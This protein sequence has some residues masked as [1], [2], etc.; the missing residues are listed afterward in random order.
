[1]TES[2]RKVWINNTI[3]NES[4]AKVPIYDSALMF[5]DMVFEMTRS[6]NSKHFLLEEHIER[7][8][9]SAEYVNIDVPYSKSE[10]LSGIEEITNHHNK[11][12]DKDDEHR[13]MINLS[14]GLLGIYE[15]NV[16]FS[17]KGPLLMI[18]DFPLKW[19]VSGMSEYFD[20][21][22]YAVVPEQK[23][24]PDYLLNAAIKNRSRLHYMMANIEVSKKGIPRAWAVLEDPEGNICE[25]TGSNIFFVKN[26]ELVT[27][28][29]K[30]MLRGISRQYVIDLAIK[31]GIKVDEREVKKEEVE[32][33]DEAFF[34]ATPFCMVPCSEIDGHK[35][36]FR[37]EGSI[38]NK[39][40]DL[41][42]NEVG[43]D[44]EKQIKIWDQGE[45]NLGNNPT[46]YMFNKEEQ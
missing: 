14:R 38:Y 3:V 2:G 13:L 29:P 30:N 24:I 16:D 18:A 36:K 20:K 44:I 15:N 42:S 8:C 22:I 17:D 46:P 21:G 26:N 31:N 37:E 33:F 1:M 19:T 12:F 27:P 10:I 32:T 9:D 11:I 43:L 40:I 5:G 23:M 6:F 28:E 45:K 7:L 4:E 39:L 35:L 41:W 25:G 34:T